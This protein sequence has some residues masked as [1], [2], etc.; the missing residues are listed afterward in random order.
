MNGRLSELKAAQGHMHPTHLP[1][2]ETMAV[3]KCKRHWEMQSS[4]VPKH[5]D[6]VLV[7][8]LHIWS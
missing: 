3:P 6:T 4:F 7:E 2:V 8:T 1:L 5:R